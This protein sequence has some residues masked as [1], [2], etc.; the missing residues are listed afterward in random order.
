MTEVKKGNP[1]WKPAHHLPIKNTPPGYR[2]KWCW[3][4]PGNISR[5]EAEGWVHP[6]Q[7]GQGDKVERVDRTG[8]QDGKAL[9]A[10]EKVY[11]ELRLMYLPQDL[12]EARTAYIAARTRQQTESMKKNLQTELNKGSDSPVQAQ[13]KIIIE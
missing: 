13:G 10:S 8:I 11:R 1:V 12:Y 9:T 4:D 5:L 3:N 6:S 7:V 2:A